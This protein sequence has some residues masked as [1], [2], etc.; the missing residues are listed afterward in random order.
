M[1][2]RSSEPATPPASGARTT[3]VKTR[4]H[5]EDRHVT[6]DRLQQAPFYAILDAGYVPSARWSPVCAALIR[7]GADLIQVRAK[8]LTRAGRA[9]LLEEIL[10]QFAPG[11]PALV[12]NDDLELARAHPGVGLHIGQSDT[13]AEEARARLGPGRLLGL[14]THSRSQA[15]AA[16][17]LPP[18]TLD[19]FAVGPVFSTPTKPEYEPVGLGLVREVAAMRPALPWFCIGGIK[20]GNVREVLDAGAARVVVV[21]DVLTADDP[22]LVIGEIRRHVADRLATRG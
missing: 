20:R 16:L 17:A 6:A 18:G 2:P 19:Y 13:P 3:P 9:A 14:S 15:A 12:V 7:G 4:P 21:S 10:P 11:G 1:M 5:G 22:A 8:A